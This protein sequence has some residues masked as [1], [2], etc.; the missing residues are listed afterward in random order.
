MDELAAL[1]QR[2]AEL[3]ATEAEHRRMEETLKS[4]EERLK[5]IFEFAPDAYYLSDLGGHLVDGNKAAEALIGYE[6]SELIGQSFLRLG[7]LSPDQIAK[8]AALLAQNILGKRTGPDEFILNRK[9]GT[10]VVAE[11]STY[12]VR[13]D[14]QVMVLGIA[15]NI[16]ERKRVE[17]ERE[18]LVIELREALNQV[19]TLS[20]LLP[21]C[22]NCKK[23]RDDQGY[24]HQVEA[25]VRDH[26]EAE[27]SH[28]ICPDCLTELYPDFLGDKE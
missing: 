4:S 17:E 15:R 24:W 27:F 28:S 11:I 25:Y 2:V 20:G 18:S 1:R 21:I 12:P 6:R 13:I 26:S 3:E 14:G 23:I 7:L 22:A 8:A 9:D 16:T 5:I 19:Q 10:R